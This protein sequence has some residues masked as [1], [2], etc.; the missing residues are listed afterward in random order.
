MYAFGDKIGSVSVAGEDLDIFCN[1][2][3]EKEPSPFFT[4]DNEGNFLGICFHCVE[5]VR[6][7]LYQK[8]GKNMAQIWKEGHAEDWWRKA[9]LIGAE[10]ISPIQV[11]NSQIALQAGD[12]ICFSGGK[13]GH[14]GIVTKFF[15]ENLTAEF[16]H[17]NFFIDERDLK[18]TIFL[19]EKNIT[20]DGGD[21]YKLQGFLRFF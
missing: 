13:F 3:Y 7:F 16:C 21:T 9:D 1:K 17:Q 15:P 20:D 4:E 14:V 19:P 18:T 6:R 5:L 2:G 12:I 8:T 10:K 11:S